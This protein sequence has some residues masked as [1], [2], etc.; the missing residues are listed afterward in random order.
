MNAIRLDMTM[1]LDGSPPV[2]IIDP[3]RRWDV[4]AS[5]FSTDSTTAT[6]QIPTA[7]CMPRA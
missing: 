3:D 4:V 1:S 5:R 2:P 7:R 6:A